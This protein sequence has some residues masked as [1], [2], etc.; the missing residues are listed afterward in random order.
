M[1]ALRDLMLQHGIAFGFLGAGL[2]VAVGIALIPKLRR[3]AVTF[4]RLLGRWFVGDAG[5]KRPAAGPRPDRYAARTQWMRDHAGLLVE[6]ADWHA[7]EY[8][9]THGEE[10]QR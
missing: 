8:D 7:F 1:N 4:G 9:A 3:D 6:E 2:F 5:R 10:A